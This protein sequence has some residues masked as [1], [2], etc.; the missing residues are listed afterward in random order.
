MVARMAQRCSEVAD[1]EALTATATRELRALTGFDCVMLMRRRGD[2]VEQLAASCRSGSPDFGALG[3]RCTR[4]EQLCWIEDIE[5]EPVPLVSSGTSQV[6]EPRFLRCGE[7]EVE[8]ELR[9]AGVR[10]VLLAPIRYG[11]ADLKGSVIAL[12]RTPKAPD[13]SRLAAVELFAAFLALKIENLEL[14]GSAPRS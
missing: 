7:S 8:D 6:A 12:H 3:T 5:S 11:E 1:L 10:S 4:N 13:L 14:R 9:R 2:S